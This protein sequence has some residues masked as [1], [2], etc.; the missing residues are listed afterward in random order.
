MQ[1][2]VQ[3]SPNVSW[4]VNCVILLLCVLSGFSSD[5]PPPHPQCFI[6]FLTPAADVCVSSLP[7]VFLPSHCVC[8]CCAEGVCDSGPA[9]SDVR[10]AQG[11]VVPHLPA[12]PAP[13]VG[14]RRPRLLLPPLSSRLLPLS[15]CGGVCCPFLPS[16]LSSSPSFPAAFWFT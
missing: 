4:C 1:G 6:L 16:F 8:V 12:P 13:A 15:L 11:G 7:S 14:S 9:K 10:D 5:P 3:S 2:P